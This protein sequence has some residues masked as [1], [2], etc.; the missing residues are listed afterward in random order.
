LQARRDLRGERGSVLAAVDLDHHAP[1]ALV[2]QFQR[3]AACGVAEVVGQR[4]PS[5]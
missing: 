2:L 5:L 3:G 4:A 1:V